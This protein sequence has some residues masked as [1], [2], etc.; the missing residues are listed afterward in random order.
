M[1]N[2]IFCGIL[3]FTERSRRW[4]DDLDAMN[5]LRVYG[6]GGLSGGQGGTRTLAEFAEHFDGH[7]N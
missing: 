1:L 2:E 4:L 5:F 7:P 3:V 6:E